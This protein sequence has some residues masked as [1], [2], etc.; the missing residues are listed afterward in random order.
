MHYTERALL[1]VYG[2]KYI[3]LHVRASNQ[4]AFHL[5]HK[6]LKFDIHKVELKYY[7]DGEDGYE[8]RKNLDYEELGLPK[9]DEEAAAPAAAWAAGLLAASTAR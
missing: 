9:P 8:M 6:T 3:A 2:A 1:E 7:S 4:G 5:Y